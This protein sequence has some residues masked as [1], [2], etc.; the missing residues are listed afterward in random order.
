MSTS[1]SNSNN[2]PKSPLTSQV[3]G[4]HYLGMPIQ[5]F[6]Y[7][8]RNRLG[9]CEHTAIKYLTRHGSKGKAQDVVKAIH[10]CIVLLGLEY[11]EDV[12]DSYKQIM[13][14]IGVNDNNHLND[15]ND[16]SAT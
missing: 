2:T 1:S 14:M 9:P 6:E 11:P 8:H 3:G 15:E 4:R 12:A 10:T 13:K 16:R 7:S 5:P